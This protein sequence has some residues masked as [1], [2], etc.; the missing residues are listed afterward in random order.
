MYAVAA[1]LS[2]LTE[3]IQK[4]ETYVKTTQAEL[5]DNFGTK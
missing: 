3:N 5:Y 4:L 2:T 1:S